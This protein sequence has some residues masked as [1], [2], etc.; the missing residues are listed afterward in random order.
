MTTRGTPGGRHSAVGSSM[1]RRLNASSTL[2]A[3]H[4]WYGA[5]SAPAGR[6][7]DDCTVGPAGLRPEPPRP[8]PL[9]ASCH[10]PRSVFP[11][12]QTPVRSGFLS[13]VRGTA[14]RDC[15]A[16]DDTTKVSTAATT[17]RRSAFIISPP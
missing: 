7:V 5:A 4:G 3:A 13:G 15:E 6:S 12:C 2:L 11:A 16:A 9:L 1:P 14:L 8:T 17:T 10:E